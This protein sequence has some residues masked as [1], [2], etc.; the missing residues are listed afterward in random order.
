MDSKNTLGWQNFH[1]CRSAPQAPHNT[2]EHLFGGQLSEDVL[3][4]FGYFDVNADF[5]A[6]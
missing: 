1:R 4:H 2:R 3:G 6:K 5:Y